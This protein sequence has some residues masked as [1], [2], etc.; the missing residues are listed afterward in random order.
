MTE[1]EKTQEDCTGFTW[2]GFGSHGTAAVAAV[3]RQQKLPPCQTKPVPAGFKT[4][5]PPAKAEP[6]SGV[7]SVSV[8]AYSRNG[9]KGCAAP[10]G[11][12]E[13]KHVRNNSADIKFSE[14]GVGEDA[15]GTGAEI[16]LQPMEVQNGADIHLQP[17]EDPTLQKVDVP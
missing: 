10:P 12:E 5:S 11:R 7:G 15:P 6:N 3:K 9:R 2:Q 16:P 1:E 14:E 13:L 17:V 8:T 4:D